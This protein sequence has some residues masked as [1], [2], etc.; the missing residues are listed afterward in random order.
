MKSSNTLTPFGKLVVKA[1]V[2]QDMTKTELADQIGAAGNSLRE[3]LVLDA[4]KGCGLLQRDI[5]VLHCRP[6][7]LLLCG[8]R[9]LHLPGVEGEGGDDRRDV[10]HRRRVHYG[11]GPRPHHPGVGG[12]RH[13]PL[14]GLRRAASRAFRAHHH[15][16]SSFWVFSML[17]SFP[18]PPRAGTIEVGSCPG[19]G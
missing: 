1:L 6:S 4:L 14:A 11:R 19:R 16:A 8:H 7:L 10:L 2:D 17:R 12:H 5:C 18:F 9:L 3:R 13:Q 15:A